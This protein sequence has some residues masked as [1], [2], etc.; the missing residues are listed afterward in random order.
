MIGDRLCDCATDPADLQSLFRI[1]RAS[2]PEF[3]QALVSDAVLKRPTVFPG[4]V[5]YEDG[6]PAVALLWRFLDPRKEIVTVDFYVESPR[7]SAETVQNIIA[8]FMEKTRQVMNIPARVCIRFG[9]PQQR[10]ILCRQ[11][12]TVDRAHTSVCI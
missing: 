8:G 9:R 7:A 1:Y 6:E 12:E 11:I 2:L 10:A 4:L 3:K 5:G